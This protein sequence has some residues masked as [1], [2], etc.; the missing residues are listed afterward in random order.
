MF[1]RIY[2]IIIII[3]YICYFVGM[4]AYDLLVNFRNG[5][6]EKLNEEETID[7]SDEMAAFEPIPI[8]RQDVQL[9]AAP[10]RKKRLPLSG[11]TQMTGGINVDELVATLEEAIKENNVVADIIKTSTEME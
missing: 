8:R 5:V 3:G 2:V 1:F 7:I 10:K 9:P 4:I 6:R 11:K